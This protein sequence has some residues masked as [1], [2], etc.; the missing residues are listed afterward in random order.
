MIKKIFTFLFLCF[1]L[2]TSFSSSLSVFADSLIYNTSWTNTFW[3]T[4]IPA[5]YKPWFPT[6]Q[7]KVE[8]PSWNVKPSIELDGSKWY[9]YNVLAFNT[10]SLETSYALTPWYNPQSYLVFPKEKFWTFWDITLQIKDLQ[11]QDDMWRKLRPVV[12]INYYDENNTIILDSFYTDSSKITLFHPIDYLSAGYQKMDIGTR[13]TPLGPTAYGDWTKPLP[14]GPSTL[15]NSWCKSTTH[16]SIGWVGSYNMDI[17]LPLSKFSNRIQDY[18]Q[19]YEEQISWE[20]TK[21]PLAKL[22]YVKIKVSYVSLIDPSTVTDADQQGSSY[23]KCG[24]LREDTLAGYVDGDLW[25]TLLVKPK[26]ETNWNNNPFSY[27]FTMDKSTNLLDWDS[28]ENTVLTKF[29]DKSTTPVTIT[30]KTIKDLRDSQILHT[31]DGLVFSNG[32]KYNINSAVTYMWF[33][34]RPLS[35]GEEYKLS[36]I[37]TDNLHAINVGDLDD[38]SQAAGGWQYG[39]RNSFTGEIVKRTWSPSGSGEELLRSRRQ[40][41]DQLSARVSWINNELK[42][43]TKYPSYVIDS[44]IPNPT[45]ADY[46]WTRMKFPLTQVELNG[47]QTGLQWIEIKKLNF[48]DWVGWTLPDGTHAKVVKQFPVTVS[49]FDDMSQFLLVWNQIQPTSG[50]EY[51]VKAD[52]LSRYILNVNTTI[53]ASRS[54]INSKLLEP[55]TSKSAPNLTDFSE[56]DKFA[57]F[58]NPLYFDELPIVENRVSS[59]G[60]TNLKLIYKPLVI[61]SE[62]AIEDCS[63]LYIDDVSTPAKKEKFWRTEEREVWT[64]FD[65]IDWSSDLTKFLRQYSA[66]QGFWF[67]PYGV[68]ADFSSNLSSSEYLLGFKEINSENYP[69]SFDKSQVQEAWLPD[70]VWWS[71]SYDWRDRAPVI[72][73]YSSWSAIKWKI[74]DTNN[75]VKWTDLEDY[76]LKITTSNPSNYQTCIDSHVPWK[77]GYWTWQYYYSL[78]DL[79]LKFDTHMSE[80]PSIRTAIE[81][82]YSDLTNYISLNSSLNTDTGKIFNWLFIPESTNLDS[83]SRDPM[84]EWDIWTIWKTVYTPTDKWFF[85]GIPKSIKSELDIIN[86]DVKTDERIDQ[87]FGWQTVYPYDSTL[88][89]ISGVSENP[90]L[91]AIWYNIT[92]PAGERYLK[93]GTYD[94]DSRLNWGTPSL[95]ISYLIR[96]VFEDKTL[97]KWDVNRNQ[98]WPP[99]INIWGVFTPSSLM[100]PSILT[101]LETFYSNSWK[102]TSNNLWTLVSSTTNVSHPYTVFSWTSKSQAL[103]LEGPEGNNSTEF[104]KVDLYK[105]QQK[106]QKQWKLEADWDH[107]KDLKYLSNWDFNKDTKRLQNNITLRLVIKNPDRT[108]TGVSKPNILYFMTNGLTWGPVPDVSPNVDPMNHTVE[109]L[110]SNKVINGLSWIWTKTYY[111]QPE[112]LTNTWK[113]VIKSTWTDTETS[114]IVSLRIYWNSANSKLLENPYLALSKNDNLDIIKLSS[115]E[116]TDL[117]KIKPVALEKDAN[118]WNLDPKISNVSDLGSW[119]SVDPVTDPLKDTKIDTTANTI[120]Y[121][122]WKTYKKVCIWSESVWPETFYKASSD[123]TTLQLKSNTLWL[124]T[125][126]KVEIPHQLVCSYRA[127]S[128]TEATLRAS[129]AKRRIPSADIPPASTDYTDNVLPFVDVY[130]KVKVQAARLPVTKYYDLLNLVNSPLVSCASPTSYD[131]TY[132]TKDLITQNAATI[133]TQQLCITQDKKEVLN[134]FIEKN[135]LPSDTTAQDKRTNLNFV[136][137]ADKVDD[138]NTYSS[139]TEDN[140]LNNTA[141]SLQYCIDC[142]P[143]LKGNGVKAEWDYPKTKLENPPGNPLNQSL[144]DQ[145]DLPTAQKNIWDSVVVYPKIT[146]TSGKD[147]CLLTTEKTAASQQISSIDGGDN[148]LI[149]SVSSFAD[150]TVKLP[151]STGTILWNGTITSDLTNARQVKYRYKLDWINNNLSY[152]VK[153][154]YC[155]EEALPFNTVESKPISFKVDSGGIW[156]GLCNLNATLPVWNALVPRGSTINYNITCTNTTT[157]DIYDLQVKLPTPEKI[158]YKTGLKE[159]Y[160]PLG[161]L[162]KW[163][164]ISYETNPLDLVKRG[165]VWENTFNNE[166]IIGTLSS[167]YKAQEGATTYVEGADTIKH[168]VTVPPDDKTTTTILRGPCDNQNQYDYTTWVAP[169]QQYPYKPL[170]GMCI[171][172]LPATDLNGV[173]QITNDNKACLVVKYYRLGKDDVMSTNSYNNLYPDLVFGNW[174]RINQWVTNNL[175]PAS[176]ATACNSSVTNTACI[177]RNQINSINDWVEWSVRSKYINVNVDTK[178][179]IPKTFVTDWLA[180]VFTDYTATPGLTS[181]I[182]TDPTNNVT[183]FKVAFSDLAISTESEVS[184]NDFQKVLK[185]WASS[186][187]STLNKAFLELR[188]PLV[189]KNKGSDS[190]STITNLWGETVWDSNSVKVNSSQIF[191]DRQRWLAKDNA[192]SCN[193]QWVSST[194]CGVSCG[195]WGCFCNNW[196]TVYDYFLQNDWTTTDT[197]IPPTTWNSFAVTSQD[198]IPVCISSTWK[199]FQALNWGMY[200]QDLAGT[201]WIEH[202]VKLGNPASYNT[203]WFLNQDTWTTP[204]GWFV[205][206]NGGIDNLFNLDQ[207]YNTTSCYPYNPQLNEYDYSMPLAPDS[208]T[209]KCQDWKYPWF[210]A[211]KNGQ[212]GYNYKFSKT[213]LQ[214][215]LSSWINLDTWTTWGPTIKDRVWVYSQVDNSN[216][217]LVIWMTW[218]PSVKVSWLGSIFVTRDINNLNTK[219][220]PYD[221][222]NPGNLA[223]TLNINSNVLYNSD[224]ITTWNTMKDIT[225]D[226]MAIV[227]NG[228]LKIGSQVE[229][230]D[231][232]YFVDWDVI[233]E[234]SRNTIE[235]WNLFVTWK[236]IVRRQATTN[237]QVD[238]FTGTQDRPVLRITGDKKRSIFLQPR[239]LQEPN[240]YYKEQAVEANDLNFDCK[241]NG[242]CN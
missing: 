222:L 61:K 173:N 135:Y 8:F 94:L 231:W 101:W 196:Q 221:S 190:T 42:S 206:H 73:Y 151:A 35:N 186:N 234:Q 39:D 164:T 145:P 210:Y 217:D 107:S 202:Q 169:G 207:K 40:L 26:V 89:P 5:E 180:G 52:L 189:V 165:T 19:D 133:A 154:K 104:Y 126:Q 77:T 211:V 30:K 136:L 181:Q 155:W 113:N 194:C 123:N 93:L 102:F 134:K 172:K 22:K 150:W 70:L 44:N 83:I 84:T 105:L 208:V 174:I 157:N 41:Q 110:S 95:D 220:L 200:V 242:S 156:G 67:T 185:D 178:I 166:I 183:T 85:W 4:F 118:Y 140:K 55:V 109:L 225:G 137:W 131:N 9:L 37:M 182:L 188:I 128:E 86:S 223:V 147:I 226:S 60:N 20:T 230:L 163:Q 36:K 66:W 79:G 184:N 27:G 175:W 240:K 162:P 143:K 21:T 168:I 62:F 197:L 64:P 53:Q 227:V 112:D 159:D 31:S 144:P 68:Q 171:A 192:V 236:V 158:V 63:K 229:K 57:L 232:T 216:Q 176:H 215:L 29:T 74:T 38:H 65:K 23:L 87:S 75:K 72:N 33:L 204:A 46:H 99:I 11:L 167:R 161:S 15:P 142:A 96:P 115:T 119:L 127:D 203:N 76:C 235:I 50:I 81:G 24:G 228:N 108:Q 34:K 187:V 49:L 239:I 120:K 198:Q 82:T 233:I 238:R 43:I 195:K 56:I 212:Y 103:Q 152:L 28:Y 138:T 153:Y 199:W 90:G 146:N 149:T 129:S 201:T 106:L 141:F 14:C 13:Q 25:S 98:F 122:N 130:M 7:S 170:P 191:F 116:V 1:F 2:V 132:S 3:A 148:Q 59:S 224:T 78:Y 54:S 32:T 114:D 58:Y 179:S 17:V 193:A 139:L 10:Q 18:N 92:I 213:D 91:A 6:N 100:P 177:S 160:I 48:Q 117:Q 97:S 121:P 16:W 209:N 241:Y 12:S 71:P 47:Y 218:V 125:P 111:V 80:D 214:G 69:N 205:Q 237:S 219:D 51:M 88:K 45:W 124:I